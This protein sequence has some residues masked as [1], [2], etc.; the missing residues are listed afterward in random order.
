MIVFFMV[1]NHIENKKQVRNYLYAMLIA[2]A[3][4]SIIGI[5]Q[6]PAGGRIS[7]PSLRDRLIY[8]SLI[9]L[10]TIPL[11]F[12]QSRS[13][14]V[15]M[16]PAIL[17][18]LRLSEKKL[19]VVTA[20]VVLG[21][22]MT[23]AAPEIA[24]ERVMYTFLQGQQRTDVIEVGGLKLDTSTSAR[25]F[26]WISAS[27]DWVKHPV[28]GF[29]ITGY[30]FLD[31]QYFRVITETGFLGLFLFFLLMISI[32]KNTYHVFK[33][34]TDPL[35]KGLSMG[36]L[37]GFVGLLFHAIAANTFIIVRIMEPF[38]FMAAMVMMI[39]KVEEVPAQ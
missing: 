18:F 7:A 36:F 30:R 4:V 19:W 39:P 12:T 11:F 8:V 3:I 2:C 6:I 27:R 20:L 33:E 25:V 22:G 5:S 34:A 21:L 29:G 9:S 35:H 28:L 26:S 13:S 17:I 24:R 14:Y 38:W 37:A 23:F 15:A 1:A 31:A 32:Y 16:I 10:F